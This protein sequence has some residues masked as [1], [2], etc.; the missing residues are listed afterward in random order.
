[1]RMQDKFEKGVDDVV[2]VAVREISLAPGGWV[3]N[4]TKEELR[5]VQ[6]EDEIMGKLLIL[7]ELGGESQRKKLFLADPS[8]K[9]NWR[10]KDNLGIRGGLLKYNWMS[11]IDK[12]LLVV[13]EILKGTVLEFCHSHMEIEKTKSCIL[14][15]AIW[16]NLRNSCEEPI[17]G[18]A[19]C[20][21]KIRDVWQL[22]E[23]RL[24][25]DRYEL[26]G[27]LYLYDETSDG[28]TDGEQLHIGYWI[29]L[30]ITWLKLWQGW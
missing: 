16:Y 24:V 2:P 14:E 12:W 1:M 7:L 23:Q 20:K 29:S 18:C 4:Y 28:N 5:K 26:E 30:K 25:H 21:G 11:G 27:G 15:R 3:E 13:P 22:G 17:N 19:V 9:Y 10:F 8:V 6:L